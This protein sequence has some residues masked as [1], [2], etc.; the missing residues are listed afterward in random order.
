MNQN[1]TGNRQTNGPQSEEIR[2]DDEKRIKVLSPTMLVFKRFLRNKLA[3]VGLV[4]LILMFLFSF[5]GGVLSP[6]Q[7]QQV[8]RKYEVIP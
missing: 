7:Q 4:I 5:L 3:I 1:Q 6:Y 8:F 2:L